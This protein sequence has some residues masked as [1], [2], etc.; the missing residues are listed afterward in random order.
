VYVVQAGDT[1]LEIALRHGIPASALAEANGLYW[2]SWVYAGQRLTIP[3]SAAA[4]T[5]P[6]APT[7]GGTYVVQPGDNLFR[8]GLRHGTTAAA[9]R[10]TN[11]LSSNTIYVGQRLTIPGGN[12]NPPAAQPA[13]APAPVG[14]GE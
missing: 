7:D 13:P 5:P 11:G 4:P 6:A 9:L 12:P 10:A 2:N 3:G 8:I 14:Y 1:L